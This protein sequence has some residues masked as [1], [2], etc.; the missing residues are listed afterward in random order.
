MVNTRNC[1]NALALTCALLY[2]ACAV[3]VAVLPAAYLWVLNSWS[4]GMDLA[5]LYDPT[6]V[7]NFAMVAA[8]FV[9]FTIFG[10]LSG[11]LCALLYNRLQSGRSAR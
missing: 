6:K 8:G 10:W 5:T 1:A 7:L 2:V 4:H 11:A 9:T 3:F